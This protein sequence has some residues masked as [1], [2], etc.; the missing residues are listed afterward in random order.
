MIDL[1]FPLS[2]I[3]K[4]GLA[5]DGSREDGPTALRNSLIAAFAEMKRVGMAVTADGWVQDESNLLMAKEKRH[6]DLPR[7]YPGYIPVLII[8]TIPPEPIP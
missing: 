8:R 6:D 2:V 4:M 3:E 5:F 1:V 7:D